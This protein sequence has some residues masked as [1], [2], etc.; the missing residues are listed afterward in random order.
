VACGGMS[1]DPDD[2]TREGIVRTGAKIIR[3]GA[4]V[5]PGSMF[6]YALWD[7][8]T[9]IG[10]PACVLHDPVTT[11]DLLLPR[12]LVGEKLTS[13]DIGKLGHG[14]LCLH[15]SDCI[16]PICPFGWG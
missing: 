12:I 8:V 15:C 9:I 1:V 14:G 3:Y 11:F 10:A 2:V 6:L 5:L 7:S 4:P 13:L 16:Y